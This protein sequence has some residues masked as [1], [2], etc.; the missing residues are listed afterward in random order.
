M[1]FNVEIHRGGHVEINND[2]VQ[3]LT[4]QGHSAF[5][6]E[7]FESFIDG[8]Q[9]IRDPLAGKIYEHLWKTFCD[10]S[11]MINATQSRQ[12]DHQLHSD[13]VATKGK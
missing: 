10:Y 1:N 3:W 7:R 2:F 11:D 5:I 12:S 8:Y 6:G 13:V 4:K 9:V